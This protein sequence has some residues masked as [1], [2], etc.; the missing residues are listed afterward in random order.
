MGAAGGWDSD[1]EDSDSSDED[2]L[3]LP[4][5]ARFSMWIFKL[6]FRLGLRFRQRRWKCT[7]VNNS[8]EMS[9]DI[10]SVFTRIEPIDIQASTRPEI[11][12]IGSTQPMETKAVLTSERGSDKETLNLSENWSYAS[13]AEIPS[14]SSVGKSSRS[15]LMKGRPSAR[16]AGRAENHLASY[17]QR[18]SQ[19]YPNETRH[20]PQ[21][22]RHQLY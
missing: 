21:S 5:V 11:K 18:R 4:T 17:L 7:Q 12:E 20:R 2:S 9:K 3:P 1:L 22:R 16:K 10:D 13:T 19:K 6:Q 15:S 14:G 8:K